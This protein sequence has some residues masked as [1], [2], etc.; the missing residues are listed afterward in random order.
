[1]IDIGP[2]GPN[3]IIDGIMNYMVMGVI[4]TSF[5]AKGWGRWLSQ[6][7]LYV[8]SHWLRMPTLLLMKHLTIKF[9]RR[10]SDEQH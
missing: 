10:F 9:I 5:G 1:M 8:R 3:I 4:S 2:Y 7:G 6:N